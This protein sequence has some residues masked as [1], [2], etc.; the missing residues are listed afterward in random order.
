MNPS[1]FHEWILTGLVSWKSC[2]DN[3]SCC[4]FKSTTAS[5]LHSALEFSSFLSWCSLSLTCCRCYRHL[6]GLA[7]KNNMFSVLCIVTVQVLLT[8]AKGV[9]WPKLIAA[10]SVGIKQLFRRQFDR[11]ILST[12]KKMTAVASLPGPMTFLAFAF[13]QVYSTRHEGIKSN[14][15]VVW[16]PS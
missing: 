6:Y 5:S 12:L 3:H 4:E 7:S 1:P 16:L 10:C 14:H 8:T 2:P 15:K 9:F 13:G 11:H